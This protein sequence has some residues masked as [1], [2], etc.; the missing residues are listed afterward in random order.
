MSKSG[1]I[2][3][4]EDDQD[5]KEF[6]EKIFS[7]LGIENERVY[8]KNSQEALDYLNST[9]KSLFLI[10]CDVNLAG[11]NG[12]ELK[13]EIDSIPYLRLK[14]IPFVFYSTSIRQEQVIEAYSEL[15]V[16]GFFK[17]ENDFDQAKTVV[18]TILSYWKLC[19]HPNK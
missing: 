18:S 6:M 15:T 10:L 19:R 3:L 4:L 13:R 9:S 7:E 11:M 14:S 2:V 1:P 16:Q 12:L 8:L 5:D 17:K